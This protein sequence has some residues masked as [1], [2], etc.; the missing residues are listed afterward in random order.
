MDADECPA[1][2]PH[3]W[4]DDVDERYERLPARDRWHCEHCGC[5]PP[6]EDPD[7]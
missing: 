1:G 4:T 5:A 3:I 7:L 2:G 6:D